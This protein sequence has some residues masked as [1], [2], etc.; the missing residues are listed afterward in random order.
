MHIEVTERDDAV[1]VTLDGELEAA[2]AQDLAICLAEI[3]PESRLVI[4]VERLTFIDSTGLGVLIRAANEAH[5]QGKR[6]ALVRP[7][8]GVSRLLHVVDVARRFEIREGSP[9]TSERA[10]LTA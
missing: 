6:V 3:L 9:V 8:P 1:W 5:A 10:E 4:D 7:Q 2:T